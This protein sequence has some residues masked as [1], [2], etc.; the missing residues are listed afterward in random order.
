MPKYAVSVE[1]IYALQK[2]REDLLTVQEELNASNEKLVSEIGEEAEN[3]G[4]Y[5]K[6]ILEMAREVILCCK[7]SEPAIEYLTSMSI[8]QLIDILYNL[9]GFDGDGGN[10]DEWPDPQ[11]KVKVLRR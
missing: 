8:P 11:Q 9:I 10:D 1:G 6:E 3:L 2:L 5:A 7:K 4:L